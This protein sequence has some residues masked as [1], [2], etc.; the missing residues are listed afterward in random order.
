MFKKIIKNLEHIVNFGVSTDKSVNQNKTTKLVNLICLFW[1]VAFILTSILSY[2]VGE[3]FSKGVLVNSLGFLTVLICHL[4]NKFKQLT[5][6]RILLLT[7]TI[8]YYFIVTTYMAPKRFVEFFYL[9]IPTGSLIFF[10]RYIYSWIF[11]GVCILLFHYTF[12][13]LEFYKSEGVLFLPP[14]MFFLF[15]MNFLIV[16]YFKKLN[17][18]NEGL[19]A[20]QR[21]KVLSDKIVLEKQEAELRK[22]NEFKSHFFVN[23]SHEIRTPITLIKGYTLSLI[24]I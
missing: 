3:N 16:F 1:Y 22:L 17:I 11:L 14:L 19:L 4:L 2:T 23:L 6:A 20:E 8:I 24:H 7:F 5:A 13:H 18:K 21:D 15:L 9:L 12:L 10:D